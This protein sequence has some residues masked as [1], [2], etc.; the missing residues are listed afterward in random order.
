MPKDSIVVIAPVGQL[1]EDF[2]LS[3]FLVYCMSHNEG[4]FAQ[5]NDTDTVLSY[6]NP[7]SRCCLRLT[8]RK[9]AWAAYGLRHQASRNGPSCPPY[10]FGRVGK[11]MNGLACTR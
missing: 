4:I 8:N 5:R 3:P 7:D 1:M 6:S 2:G 10:F 9:S 11:C